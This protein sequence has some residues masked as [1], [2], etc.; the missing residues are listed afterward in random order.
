MAKLLRITDSS[1]VFLALPRHSPFVLKKG[2]LLFLPL[3][4]R[5]ASSIE[6]QKAATNLKLG[7]LRGL[8]INRSDRQ[9]PAWVNVRLTGSRYAYVISKIRKARGVLSL[10][11]VVGKCCSVTL[12]VRFS[13]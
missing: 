6:I 3:K 5:A 4:P 11:W 10:I 9:V 2:I 13:R 8:S 12:A 1:V 7:T